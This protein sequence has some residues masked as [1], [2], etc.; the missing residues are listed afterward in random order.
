MHVPT[1]QLPA[2]LSMAPREWEAAYRC[3]KP[4]FEDWV[5][6]QCRTNRRAAWAAQVA[7]DAGWPRVLVYRQVC[8]SSHALPINRKGEVCMFFH[9]LLDIVCHGCPEQGSYI[10]SRDAVTGRVHGPWFFL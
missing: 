6:M 8:V 3:P 2:A 1:D 5:V 4:G 10:A 9:A 7:Q